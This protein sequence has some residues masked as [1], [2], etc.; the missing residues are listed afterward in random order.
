MVAT[1]FSLSLSISTV[2]TLSSSHGSSPPHITFLGVNVD[3]DKISFCTS[4]PPPISNTSTK[5]GPV[6]YPSSMPYHFPKPLLDATPATS[7]LFTFYLTSAFASHYPLPLLHCQIFHTHLPKQLKPS[8]PFI[9]TYH[10]SPHI[11]FSNL[12]T[13][14]LLPHLPSLIFCHP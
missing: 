7:L 3:I 8:P 2:S 11:L 4:D 6:P 10:P 12:C 14:S 9:T 5:P 13:C 1:L